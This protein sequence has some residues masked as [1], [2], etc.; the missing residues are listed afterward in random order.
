MARYYLE[1]SKTG[2]IKYISHLDMQRL[3]KRA[4]KRLGVPI[5]Y[6]Q[7]FNPHPK[8]GF[9]QPLS[10][11]YIGEHE[12]LEFNTSKP[13]NLDFVFPELRDS[14]PEGIKILKVEELDISAKSLA[15]IVDAA[16]YTVVLPL[17]YRSRCEDIKEILNGYM[18]QDEIIAKKREKKTKKFVD[19][20]IKNQ[21]RS[22][23]VDNYNNSIALIMN[24]DSGSNSNLSPEQVISSFIEYSNLYLKREDIE[25]IRNQIVFN[26]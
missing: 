2:Y 3:F 26:K 7:G 12:L 14:M 1:F 21:I 22:I 23:E 9:A 24:L 8:M 6:S 16:I 5:E 4:F 20:D 18:D 15:S 13:L 17:N 25:V 11:G 10:L 19:K